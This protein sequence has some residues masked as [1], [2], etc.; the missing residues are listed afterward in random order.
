MVP[1]VRI[2]DTEPANERQGRRRGSPEAQNRDRF[3]LAGR[4]DEVSRDANCCLVARQP[5]VKDGART[6][7]DAVII[8][9]HKAQQ[10]ASA[11]EIVGAH[12]DANQQRAIGEFGH[13]QGKIQT[14]GEYRDAK[15]IRIDTLALDCEWNRPRT[16][17]TE[18]CGEQA[19]GKL[20]DKSSEY[21]KWLCNHAIDYL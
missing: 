5:G 21:R 20:Q 9:I 14:T 13:A 7:S 6:I 16:L 17:N 11:T 10:F 18:E 4:K 3:G 12:S 19:E 8:R 15:I 1:A 2:A